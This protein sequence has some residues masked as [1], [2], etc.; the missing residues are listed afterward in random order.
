MVVKNMFQPPVAV[1]IVFVSQFGVT[2]TGETLSK[3]F[4]RDFSKLSSVPVK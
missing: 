2:G 3:F 4:G 1:Y